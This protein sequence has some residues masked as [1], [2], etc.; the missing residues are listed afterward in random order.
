MQFESSKDLLFGSLIGFSQ[1]YMTWRFVFYDEDNS[2][3]M[4]RRAAISIWLSS[5]L[6]FLGKN[7]QRNSAIEQTQDEIGREIGLF[8]LLKFLENVA[9]DLMAN[10]SADEQVAIWFIRNQAV[11]G[12]LSLYF[13]DDLSI[14][15]YD[16]N[17]RTVKRIKKSR[18]A[19]FQSSESSANMNPSP[20]ERIQSTKSFQ[21]LF[22]SADS[23]FNAQAIDI[24]H[25][26]LYGSGF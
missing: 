22:G 10:F 7:D 13:H 12:H 4:L 16:S 2:S 5:L 17:S 3:T 26:D 24:H 9:H 23:V 18:E 19:L 8:G 25:K 1:T 21:E 20:S 6:D 14:P 11:H 15:I